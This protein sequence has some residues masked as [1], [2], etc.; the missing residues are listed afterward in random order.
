MGTVSYQGANQMSLSQHVLSYLLGVSTISALGYF[1][2]TDEFQVYSSALLNTSKHLHLTAHQLNDVHAHIGSLEHSINKVAD[3]K[4][5]IEDVER[6]VTPLKQ[7]LKDYHAELQNV[8]DKL[9]IL[10]KELYWMSK[11]K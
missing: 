8:N 9:T 10:Q 3:E 2:L 1:Y 5:S 11:Q 6:I 7:L 4:V